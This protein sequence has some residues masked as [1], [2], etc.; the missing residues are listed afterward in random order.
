MVD[1]HDAVHTGDDARQRQ[2]LSP[3][4]DLTLEPADA[5]VDEDP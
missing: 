3:K 4:V 5:F 2:H 1:V